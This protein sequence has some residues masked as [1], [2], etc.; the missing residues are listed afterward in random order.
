MC[1][2]LIKIGNDYIFRYL[3]IFRAF[4]AFLAFKHV[5]NSYLDCQALKTFARAYSFKNSSN[6]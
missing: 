5:Q 6:F 1:L 2:S 4:Q 3:N